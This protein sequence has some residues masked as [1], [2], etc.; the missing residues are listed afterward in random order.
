MPGTLHALQ[1]EKKQL[2]YRSVLEDSL[3]SED[4]TFDFHCIRPR[5]KNLGRLWLAFTK[6]QVD[7]TCFIEMHC[8][9]L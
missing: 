9:E 4:L 7:F 8:G 6:L 5:T 2:Y 3:R 1:T